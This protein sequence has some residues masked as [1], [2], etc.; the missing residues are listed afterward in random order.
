VQPGQIQAEN[1]HVPGIYVDRIIRAP[2]IE[3]RIERLRLS[4][5]D[6]ST[7]KTVNKG[8]VLREKIAR[9]AVKEIRSGMY[10]NLGIGIPTLIPDFLPE[11]IDIT[12][13]SE[14]GVLGVGRYPYEGEQDPDLINAGKESITMIPGASLFRSSSSFAIIRGNHLDLTILGGM[15]VSKTG[16]L[17]NWVIPGKMVKGMGGAMD[18]VS[19]GSR[20]IVLMEHTAKGAPKV[21]EKCNLP[22]TGQGIVSMLVTDKAVFELHSGELVLTEI[23][24]DSSLEEVR[25]TTGFQF[26][27][28]DNLKKF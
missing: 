16:D 11:G 12:M 19:S 25:S 18:L 10:I 2:K 23:A 14:N 6:K 20:V 8:D 22:L 26:K 24:E 17:A 4:S 5:Q 1:V 3:K 7:Q 28:L 13:H 27:N 21:L 15:Q 9:R